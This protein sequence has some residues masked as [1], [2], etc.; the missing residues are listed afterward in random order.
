MKKKLTTSIVLTLPDSR[1]IVGS[2]VL[3]TT[4]IIKG[5]EMITMAITKNQCMMKYHPQRNKVY[6][7]LEDE[8]ENKKKEDAGQRD[9]DT[10]YS[11]V[12]IDLNES[13]GKGNERGGTSG[14]RY[15]DTKYSILHSQRRTTKRIMQVAIGSATSNLWTKVMM[16]VH[17]T[18]RGGTI[19]H[20]E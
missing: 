19:H 16:V 2:S 1:G 7:I 9:D 5:W 6:Q 15:S 17:S 13:D 20:K 18:R 10:S 14:V 4:T 11:S 3:N 12:V 8:G